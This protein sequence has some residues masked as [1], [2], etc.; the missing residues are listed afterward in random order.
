M[1]VSDAMAKCLKNKIKCYPVKN[2][3]GWQIEYIVLNK[4]YKFDKILNGS[5]E[6][7]K[8]M[9]K[10]YIYLSNKFC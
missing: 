2:R 7:N 6:I 1:E 4:K 5:K 8:A 3:L 10:T 9:E